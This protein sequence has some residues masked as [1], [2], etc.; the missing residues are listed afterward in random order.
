MVKNSR[1]SQWHVDSGGRQ[2][3]SSATA[4][5]TD[6]AVVVRCVHTRMDHVQQRVHQP[7]TGSHLPSRFLPRGAE[8][9]K[10]AEARGSSLAVEPYLND[11]R[12]GDT[13]ARRSGL[14]RHLEA[15]F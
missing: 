11:L 13:A 9:P 14:K 7:L 6:L 10:Q 1:K 3:L 12:T 4:A 15:A 8:I 2:L 5:F